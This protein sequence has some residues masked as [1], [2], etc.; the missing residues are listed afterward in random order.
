MWAGSLKIQ[1]HWGLFSY[2][3]AKIRKYQC[4]RGLLGSPQNRNPKSEGPREEIS[5]NFPMVKTQCDL[6]TPGSSIFPGSLLVIVNAKL[7]LKP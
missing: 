4:G 5:W 6:V 2:E 7:N 1:V 3:G